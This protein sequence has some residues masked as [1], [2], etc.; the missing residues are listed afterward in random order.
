MAL[1]AAA[2]LVFVLLGIDLLLRNR[3]A[4]DSA[5][6]AAFAVVFFAGCFIYALKRFVKPTR[7]RFC[8]SFRQCRSGRPPSDVSMKAR[9]A[10]PGGAA[11]PG[12]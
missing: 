10:G 6:L 11:L 4:A 3:A 5:T 2:A 1:S 9:L 7:A 12:T 8:S